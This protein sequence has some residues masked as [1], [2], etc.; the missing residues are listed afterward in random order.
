MILREKH[1]MVEEMR[2][3]DKNNRWEL[4]SFLQEKKQLVV[5]GFRVKE[6]AHGAIER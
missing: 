1:S 4:V 5:N 6:K 3:L 2:A